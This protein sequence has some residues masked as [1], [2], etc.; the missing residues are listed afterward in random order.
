MEIRVVLIPCK[1]NPLLCRKLSLIISRRPQFEF[2]KTG[3]RIPSEVFYPPVVCL[4]L[5]TC[6]K[7]LVEL[8]SMEIVSDVNEEA[9]QQ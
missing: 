5:I 6:C 1:V 4:V 9:T 7:F 2:R 8:G 3:V